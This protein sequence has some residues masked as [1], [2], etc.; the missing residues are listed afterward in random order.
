TREFRRPGPQT[1]GRLRHQLKT[2]GGIHEHDAPAKLVRGGQNV[3]ARLAAGNDSLNDPLKPH[4]TGSG[5]TFVDREGIAAAAGVLLRVG[6]E[7]VG[8]MFVNYR[9]SHDFSVDERSLLETLASSA[10]IAIKNRRVLDALIEID[11][12]MLMTFDVDGL[13]RRVVRR[14]VEITRADDG[15]VSRPDPIDRQLIVRAE[16]KAENHAVLPDPVTR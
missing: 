12:E 4:P 8:A 16:Y 13:L 14:A 15:Y 9:R 7:T 3:Y 10:A 1:A 2:D 6:P 5:R 11:R